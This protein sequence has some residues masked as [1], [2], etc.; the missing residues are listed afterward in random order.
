[1]HVGLDKNT[2]AANAIEFNLLVLVSA[3]VTHLGHV[4]AAGLVLLVAWLFSLVR[5]LGNRKENAGF[6]LQRG[7]RHPQGFHEAFGP[8]PTQ[9]RSC[10]QLCPC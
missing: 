9:S 1:M 7:Q 5:G 10:S 6:Y 2:D 3:P 8:D 4:V